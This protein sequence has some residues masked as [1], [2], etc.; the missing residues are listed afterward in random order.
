L[1]EDEKAAYNQQMQSSSTAA[2]GG[3]HAS[4]SALLD[5]GAEPILLALYTFYRV[6]DPI[7]EFTGTVEDLDKCSKCSIERVVEI[8]NNYL[9]DCE[10]ASLRKIKLTQCIDGETGKRH[11]NV[12]AFKDAIGAIVTPT[13]AMP[14]VSEL[15][16]EDGKTVEVKNLKPWALHVLACMFYHTNK[17]LSDMCALLVRYNVRKDEDG[18]IPAKKDYYATLKPRIFKGE[19]ASNAALFMSKSQTD[20]MKSKLEWH[21]C[22][23]DDDVCDLSEYEKIQ[24]KV[25]K[26][27]ATWMTCKA[28]IQTL[29]RAKLKAVIRG[30][31][32]KGAKEAQKVL[33][34]CPSLETPVMNFIHDVVV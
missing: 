16:F 19:M 17:E 3:R 18:S 1:T 5:A 14:I 12:K 22:D 10:K 20:F 30:K 8:Y 7:P 24:K 32:S 11:I 6:E 25:G 2:K 4:S 15:R 21:D 34:T 28:I 33:E 13:L 9:Y 31:E 23:D 29:C 26:F 27:G